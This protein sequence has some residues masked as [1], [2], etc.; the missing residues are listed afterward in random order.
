MKARIGVNAFVATSAML[1]ATLVAPPSAAAATAGCAT[2]T[3]TV[4][5][6]L[7]GGSMWYYGVG[8]HRCDGRV[9][10]MASKID[11]YYRLGPAM[12][13]THMPASTGWR[14]KGN[15]SKGKY[16]RWSQSTSRSMSSCGQVM[17]RVWVRWK[18]SGSTSYVMRDKFAY[19]K[20]RCG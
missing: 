7:S 12:N 20:P 17:I 18:Y 8:A 6:S 4:R 19:Y 5:H 3:A 11:V 1:V 10:S 13:W 16:L 14:G 9:S 15:L 2:P